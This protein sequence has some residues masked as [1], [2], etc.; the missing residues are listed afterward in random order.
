MYHDVWRL[1]DIVMVSQWVAPT[2]PREADGLYISTDEGLRAYCERARA[3]KVLAVDTEFLRERTYRPRLCLVQVCYGDQSAA[4]DPI[5][6]HDLSPLAEILEDPRV[7]KV[8]HACGQ[9]LEVLLDGMGCEVA[10]VF[11]TQLAAGFLGMRHQVSYGTLVEEYCGIRLPKAEALTDW[12][13]RPLDDEQLRYAEDD[14]LYLPGIYERQ[15]RRLVELDRLSWVRPEMEEV[16]SVEKVKRDPRK[17]YLKRKRS[18]ALTRRQPAVAREACAW[19]EEAA[20]DRDVPKKWVCSDE[21]IVEIAKRCPQSGERLRRVRGTEQMSAR[22]VSAIVAAVSRGLA[23]PADQCP[24]VEHH[25]HA[26]GDAE[27]VVDLM[28][29]FVRVVSDRTGVANALLAS[30]EDLAQFLTNR[31][32]SRLATGWRYEVVGRD[33]ERLL[34]GETGL[35]V[36]GGRVEVL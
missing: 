34:D 20:A 21:L 19:R 10:P 1:S 33:L 17:A 25:A 6:I 15:M 4:I 28:Y 31:K 35:T 22:D 2:A 14:V 8:F 26:S 24:A 12:S 18:G 9:D 36:K 16:A 30:R 5:L 13:R 27:A 32:R 3:A 11:D 29:A 7:T 23:V